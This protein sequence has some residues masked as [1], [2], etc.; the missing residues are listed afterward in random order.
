MARTR[1]GRMTERMIQPAPPL[2]VWLVDPISY[3]GMA[4]SDVGQL[5]ALTELGV[6]P[7]LVGSDSWMLEPD[8][9]PRMAVFRG[10]HGSRSRIVKGARYIASLMRLIL[11]IRRQRPDIVHWQFTEL[12]IAD[13]MT[14][15]AIRLLGVP[16]V[17]TAHELLPW[18]ASRYDQRLFSGVYRVVDRVIVHNADQQAEL[19]RRFRVGP[20]K[21]RLAPLGDY[22][23]FAT[24]DLS[25]A[26][27]R[28]SLDL[29]AGRPVALFFGTIRPAKG[30]DVLLGAWAT[31]AKRAPEALLLVTGKPFKGLDTTVITSQIRD[32]GIQQNVVTR[33]EQVDPTDTNAYYRAADVVVLPYHDIGTSGVLRYAY[34]SARPVIATAVG[35][36]RS[37]V[38]PGQTGYLV[39][40]GD[41]STLADVLVEALG[42]RS[43]LEMMGQ[44]ARRYA[45]DNFRWIDSARDLLRTYEELRRDGAPGATPI[46][47][48]SSGS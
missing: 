4:Y 44:N 39:P 15:G 21:A 18:S 2:R 19:T 46:N 47:P 10:A 38:V 5:T 43:R 1:A 8:L 12:P 20:A 7:L 23:L 11:R 6:R 42:D 3:S 22:A 13:L 33:F 40:A 41:A 32:L 37:K 34:N 30:L 24:P 45:S 29:P 17:Y 16:Q 14:M 28:S 25:Q 27:A 36:H 26:A 31:V 48:T 35:E 9:V